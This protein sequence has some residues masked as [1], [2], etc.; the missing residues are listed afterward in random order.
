MKIPKQLAVA[1]L[2]VLLQGAGR[3]QKPILPA[4]GVVDL[5][6]ETRELAA[7][8]LI[9]LRGSNFATRTS[10]V[11]GQA[12]VESLQGVT[13]ELQIGDSIKNAPL[14]LVSPETIEAQLPFD[15]TQAEIRIRVRNLDG[16]S[17]P[18]NATLL[19]AAP[20]LHT[21]VEFG[22]THVSA[23]HQ[24]GSP[25]T[26]DS[27]AAAGENISL[28][29]GGL[30]PVDPPVPA[31][32]EAPGD[33]LSYT[34]HGVTV[35]IGHVESAVSFAGLMPGT[36]GTYQ[37]NVQ[38][39]A[40]LATGLHSITVESQ[41]VSSQAGITIP[42]VNPDFKPNQF[43]VS[44]SGSPSGD[45]SREKPWDLAT[46]LAHPAAI[47][48]GDTIWMLGGDYGNRKDRFE[49]L[50]SG[51]PGRPIV[52][53]QAPG[54]R[55][56][57]QGGI[58]IRGRDAWYWG[59]EVTNDQYRDRTTENGTFGVEAFGPR[60]KLIN[61]VVH[62]TIQGF[63]FWTP[64]E[65]AEAYGNIA[66]HNG[67]KG[68]QRGH[69]HGFYTQNRTGWK[70][71]HD[72]IVF[73]QFG[74]GLQA[75]GSTAAF[76]ENYDLR[77]NVLF[78]NGL[79]AGPL[80][81]VDNIHF[82]G[83]KFVNRIRVEENFTYHTPT[84]G[85]GYNRFINTEEFPGTPTEGSIRN[86]Y[87][88][89]GQF[90]EMSYWDRLTF[91]GNTIYTTQI[92]AMLSIRPDQ[93][94]AQHAWDNN[95]YF[96][97]QVFYIQGRSN[98]VSQ[99]RDVTRLDPNSKHDSNRPQ[100]V[101]SFVRG[102]RYEPGRAHIVIY[103]WAGRNSVSVDVSKVLKRG[104]RYEIRDAQDFWGAPVAT[105]AYNG[106]VIDIPMTGG[107]VSAVIGDTVPFQPKHT[108]PEFGVFVLIPLAP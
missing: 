7:G 52:L 13:V 26:D 12:M 61:L 20:R 64:A 108:L 31:G 39:P 36:A 62:D 49:S 74:L 9:R 93:Q 28:V 81:R 60:T 19:A 4:G 75:Y 50:L 83:G 100:G 55:A 104:V 98:A 54:V 6:G 3:A 51:E 47:K 106:N 65:D 73:N 38:V 89:G 27:P 33:P 90:N 96:G 41:G 23:F 30:G 10:R 72:N 8:A 5:A 11:P 14:R 88:I 29:A 22:R 37:I 94:Y 92:Q 107:N 67:Y 99:W 45:G 24:D 58:V 76:V 1:L 68:P 53:R 85:S 17:D 16:V 101:W 40:E 87:F 77:G 42:V 59:F 44:P 105:G 21:R 82:S 103:N 70:V 15:L 80:G 95:S 43:Y 97:R 35:R 63:S 102:N 18:D 56:T 69:G 84:E 66:Y 71:I 34:V 79:A 78:N 57:I 32:A 48:P 46:A 2:L 91:T 86:N 25:V